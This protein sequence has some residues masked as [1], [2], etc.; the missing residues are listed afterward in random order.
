MTPWQRRAR[1]FVAVFAVIFAVVV[2]FAF[3]RRPPG[4]TA[5]PLAHLDPKVVFES[6]AGHVV[7]VKGTRENVAIDFEKQVTFRD[8]SSRLMNVTV[9]ATDRRDGRI[10]T[11]TGREGQVTD[12]PSS[13]SVH[14]DVRL[15]ANDGLTATTEHASYSDANGMVHAPGPARFEKGRFA[16][17]GVGM[18]YDKNKDTITILDGGARRG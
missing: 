2:F 15:T 4:S 1:V 3:R 16:G 5:P 11:L 7:Q 8:G 14:G 10:F 13:Y 12:N 6:T 9:T 18:I 17:T